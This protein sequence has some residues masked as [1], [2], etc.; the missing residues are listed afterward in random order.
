MENNSAPRSA[1]LRI[2]ALC[3]TRSSISASPVQE[4]STISSSQTSAIVPPLHRSMPDLRETYFPRS[5]S[6]GRTT[7]PPPPPTPLRLRKATITGQ[8]A[9]T[10]SSLLPTSQSSTNTT[11]TVSLP[12]SQTS[13]PTR[14]LVRYLKSTLP[15]TLTTLPI[16]DPSQPYKPMAL[17]TQTSSPLEVPSPASSC[18]AINCDLGRPMPLVFPGPGVTPLTPES[19]STV[20][21]S[22][23]TIR[24]PQRPSWS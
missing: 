5:T 20:I 3:Q 18:L 11:S 17:A 12:P 24:Q 16:S 7:T 22:L 19:P 23:P 21:V 13:V 1:R 9:H 14:A 2:L 6:S 8:L 10:C 4:N 15:S